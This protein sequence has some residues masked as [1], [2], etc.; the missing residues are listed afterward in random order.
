MKRHKQAVGVGVA[1]VLAFA[2]GCGAGMAADHDSGETGPRA[3]V[4]TLAREYLQLTQRMELFERS[5][6]ELA[7]RTPN[8]CSTD[9]CRAALQ[10]AFSRAAQEVSPG[11]MEALAQFWAD[12][13]TEQEVR[14]ALNF[15]KSASGRSMQAK[16]LA[17]VDRGTAISIETQRRIVEKATTYFCE[18]RPLEC[19]RAPGTSR[20]L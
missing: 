10:R 12:I 4:V 15:A 2:L 14:D 7:R 9:D 18:A 13:Y 17:A 1:L 3:R 19:G 11:Y 20:D 6:P 5:Y 8:R 16:S